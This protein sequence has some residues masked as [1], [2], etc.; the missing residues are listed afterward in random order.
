MIV[1]ASKKP[2]SWPPSPLFLI[3]LKYFMILQLRFNLSKGTFGGFVGPQ[4]VDH[5]DSRVSFNLPFL[6]GGLIGLQ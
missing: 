1:T 3:C 2:E 5:L 4:F 6:D